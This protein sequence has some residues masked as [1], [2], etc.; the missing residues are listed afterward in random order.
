MGYDRNFFPNIV[1]PDVAVLNFFGKT[2]R[3]SPVRLDCPFFFF[4][5]VISKPTLPTSC[6]LLHAT[7]VLFEAIWALSVSSRVLPD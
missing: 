3:W 4:F 6:C 5:S 2:R 1:A 7:V